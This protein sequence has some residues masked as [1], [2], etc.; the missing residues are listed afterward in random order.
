MKNKKLIVLASLFLM[1]ATA[2]AATA[3][4]PTEQD[5]VY[6]EY[7]MSIQGE[8]V[9]M[10]LGDQKILDVTYDQ[11]DG[12]T[13]T[14]TSSDPSV[15]A[16]DEYGKLEALKL[17]TATITATYGDLTDTCEV[18]VTLGDQLPMLQM[19]TVSDTNTIYRSN[20][21][22]LSGNVLFNGKEYD[23]VDL[24]YEVSDETVGKVEDG[25]FK[26]LTTGTT[27]VTITAS[28]RGI[29][30]GLMSKT[31]T[32]T[33]VPQI[34][35]AVNGG[36]TEIDLA[37]EA[38]DD[39]EYVV[40]SPLEIEASVD[41][42]PFD[43]N[44]ELTAGER[45]VDYDPVAKTISSKGF[46]G[47]AELTLTYEL[48]GELQT[49]IIP[50]HVVPTVYRYETV[51][52]NFSAIHG[53]V[54]TGKSLR[55]ILGADI[56][57][58]YDENGNALTVENNKIF[59]IEDSKTEAGIHTEI[60]IYSTRRGYTIELKGYSGV[61]AE[62]EDFEVFNINTIYGSGA[63]NPIDESKPIGVWDGY[64]VLLN[65]IDAT[66][67][68]HNVNGDRLYSRG[69]TNDFPCGLHGTFDGRGYTVKGMTVGAYGFFGYI[70]SG[71]TVKDVAFTEV[72]LTNVTRAATLA[73]W[74]H[75]ATIS[76]VYVQLAEGTYTETSMAGFAGGIAASTVSQCILELDA[77][78][79]FTDSSSSVFANALNEYATD[80]AVKT[81]YTDVYVITDAEWIGFYHYE[82]EASDGTTVNENR[83]FWAENK[84]P[85]VEETPENSEQTDGSTDGSTGD[86]GTVDPELPD[87]SAG[88]VDLNF[89]ITG[90]F[91]Y[92]TVEEMLAA[93]KSYSTFNAFWDLTSGT[94][95][96][97]SIG[98]DYPVYEEE[99]DA[100]NGESVGD[101]NPDWI[102]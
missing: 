85:V 11:Q 25:V 13:L 73:Q 15:V 4:G 101:F 40:A 78:C 52:E 69:Q 63:F 96:W 50:V 16:V 49:Q 47:E 65:N 26:P 97:K 92:A 12:E 76:N 42:V 56:I 61:F 70:S 9:L 94:P 19:P 77:N 95:V 5:P 79:V 81:M 102:K 58:A 39:G 45:Y 74:I 62:A 60:T 10:T 30:E 48:F 90:V 54:A 82:K 31:I 6:P 24:T 89:M 53:E 20:E 93:G 29:T 68:V 33:I 8:S 14:F 18:S 32:I 34:I 3:C 2:L 35:M 66:N 57:A 51:V 55:S 37:T 23:D 84:M 27:T 36:I 87:E 83:Y 64:Y 7:T 98:G 1:S 86:E 71:A 59:G 100:F 80:A 99:E 88:P 43:V 17:G 41:D 72:K 22:E 28:W 46:T 21:V 38:T 67:Y 75:N 44:V 91:S